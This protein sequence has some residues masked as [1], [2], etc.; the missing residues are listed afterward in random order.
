MA[1]SYYKKKAKNVA[2]VEALLSIAYYVDYL[3]FLMLL[4]LFLQNVKGT[5]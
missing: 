5:S 4:K 2:I 3:S 1:H